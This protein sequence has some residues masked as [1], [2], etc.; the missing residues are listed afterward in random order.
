MN[1]FTE[2]TS[3]MQVQLIYNFDLFAKVWWVFMLLS[4][5]FV[6]LL[7]WKPHV[8][9]K[10]PFLSVVTLRFLLNSMSLATIISIPL[11]FMV[12]SPEYDLDIIFIPYFVLLGII[13]TIFILT[14][15]YDVL[16][17]GTIGMLEY[18]GVDMNNPQAKEKFRRIKD[19][20][21]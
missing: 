14:F 9:K 11:M 7:Y 6:Y 1:N 21:R 15:F 20:L 19:M 3:G 8:Q 17:G 5:S 13:M 16:E 10:T 4:F 18:F 2:M 12:F